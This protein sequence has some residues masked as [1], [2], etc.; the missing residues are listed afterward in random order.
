M[1]KKPG[2]AQSDDI[3][4]SKIWVDD[5]HGNWDASE[6]EGI[7]TLFRDGETESAFWNQLLTSK[8]K[9]NQEI[10]STFMRALFHRDFITALQMM[11]DFLEDQGYPDTDVAQL[12]EILE[13]EG[14]IGHPE[15]ERLEELERLLPDDPSGVDDHA[16]NNAVGQAYRKSM[17]NKPATPDLVKP[18]SK[19][20]A[21]KIKLQSDDSFLV[22]PGNNS[23]NPTGSVE[24]L[25]G[26]I[27]GLMPPKL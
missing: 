25:L 17:A 20:L 26:D 23:H 14:C 8:G 24:H 21:R 16:F 2:P 19:K 9:N 10:P 13:A 18:V 1:N 4:K 6:A 12:H 11:D 3:L 7:V 27:S 22:G 15:S 5:K